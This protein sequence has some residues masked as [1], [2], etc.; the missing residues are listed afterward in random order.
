MDFNIERKGYNRAEVD[1]YL[2]KLQNEYT[3]LQNEVFDLRRRLAEANSEKQYLEKQKLLIEETMI[4]AEFSARKTIEKAQAKAKEIEENNRFDFE[5][6]GNE[7]EEKKQ[8]L[9]ALLKR[10]QYIL[11]SQLALIENKNIFNGQ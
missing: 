7:L 3:T 4:N 5:S 1:Q 8:E 11:K 6:A 9:Q 2:E 10:V